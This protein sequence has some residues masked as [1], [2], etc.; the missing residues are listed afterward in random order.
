MAC[1]ALSPNS[2]ERLCLLP[3]PNRNGL[4]IQSVLIPDLTADW[5]WL[6]I[7]I[8]MRCDSKSAPGSLNISKACSSFSAA[9]HKSYELRSGASISMLPL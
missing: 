9:L 1:N 3:T 6:Y 5:R 4:D 8:I 2:T 7:L